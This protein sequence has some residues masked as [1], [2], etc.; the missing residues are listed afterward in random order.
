MPA[1]LGLMAAFSALSLWEVRS[2][3]RDARRLAAPELAALAAVLL[4]VTA[5]VAVCLLVH[6]L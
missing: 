3:V 5:I 4:V 6:A 1:V 2:L